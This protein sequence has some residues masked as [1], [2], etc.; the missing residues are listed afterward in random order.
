M[1]YQVR[2]QPAQGVAGRWDVWRHAEGW[3]DELD[4]L[5]ALYTNP[6]YDEVYD[7]AQDALPAYVEDIRG[8]VYDEPACILALVCL[9][10]EGPIVHYVGIVSDDG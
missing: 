9:K 8:Q 7:L 10:A 3:A 6:T 2:M 5:Q 4:L 1:F